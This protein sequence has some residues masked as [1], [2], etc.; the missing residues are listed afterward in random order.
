M[1]S[2]VVSIFNSKK[3]YQNAIN[4]LIWPKAFTT[5]RYCLKGSVSR[6]M[7]YNSGFSGANRYHSSGRIQSGCQFSKL[8]VY[9]LGK[10]FRITELVVCIPKL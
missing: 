8:F 3:I 7:R 2:I 10:S 4:R 6:L 1:S 5:Y 9:I